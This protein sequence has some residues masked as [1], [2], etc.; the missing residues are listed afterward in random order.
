MLNKQNMKMRIFIFFL[1]IGCYPFLYAQTPVLHFSHITETDGLSNPNVHCIY[2]D[3][4]GFMWF[5][6][7][8]GLDQYDGYKFRK[9]VPVENDPSSISTVY[10]RTILGTNEGNLWIGTTDGLNFYDRKKDIFI[11]YATSKID[12]NSISADD[13]SSIV[14][15][16]DSN[17]WLGTTAGGLNYFDRKTKKFTHYQN[18]PGSPSSIYSNRIQNLFLDKNQNLWIGTADGVLDLSVKNS[19]QFQHIHLVGKNN[20][21]ENVDQIRAIIQDRK[22]NYWIATSGSGLYKMKILPDK[23]FEFV[24]F[25]N[26]PKDPNTVSNNHVSQLIENKEGGLWIGT[27]NGG[28]NYLDTNETRFVHYFYNE[29]NRESLGHNSVWSLFQ[30]N[31]S[32]LWVGTFTAGLNLNAAN[33][34]GFRLY[35]NIPGDTKSLSHNTVSAFFE[36]HT[37]TVWVGTDGGGLNSFNKTDGSFKHY[38]KNNAKLGS[39]AVLCIY[40]DKH[41]NLWVGTW[42]GG[43]NLLDR[44]T[45]T[46]KQFTKENSGLGCNNIITIME[47]TRGV[48][49]VGTFWG[50]GGISR[51]DEEQKRFIT[52]KAE[53]SGLPHNTVYSIINGSDNTLYLATANGLSNFDPVNNSFKNYYTSADNANSLSNNTIITLLFVKDSILWIGTAAGLN[54]LNVKT[55]KFKRYLVKDGLPN[56]SIVGIEEDQ[57]GNIWLSTGNG[58]SRLDPKTGIFKNFDMSDGLQG[59]SFYRCSHYK[60]KHGEIYFGGTK[61]YNV[62]D[63]KEITELRIKP[64]IYLTEFR[65]FNENVKVAAKN[66]PLQKQISEAGEIWLR[67]DQSVITFEFAAIYYAAPEKITYEYKLE[68]FDKAWNPV[69]EERAATYTNLNPGKYTFRVRI[70][71]KNGICNEEGT[72]IRVIVVPPFWM[73]WWFR[74]ILIFTLALILLTIFMLRTKSIQ[75]R[76]KMLEEMVDK[77]TRELQQK[78]EIMKLQSNELNETNTLLEERQQQIEEQAETLLAQKLELEHFNEELHELNATKDKFFSIIAHDIKNPFNTIL[79]FAEL[80]IHNFSKW[81]DEKK[82]Q[83][84]QVIFDSSQGLFEL[85]ENLLQW[86]RS[87]RGLIEF[88][89]IVTDLN[90]Q[91]NVAISLLKDSA[92]A[93]KIEIIP[94]FQDNDIVLTADLRMLDTIFRNILSN[95]IKFTPTGGNVR[96]TTKIENNFAVASFNDSGVGM[97]EEVISRLFRIDVHHTSTGTNEEKGTGLGLILVKEFI[98]KH[99]GKIEVQSAVD[100][101]STFILKFPL[102]K[103]GQVI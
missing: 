9:F 81:T 21:K 74:I 59:K 73:T 86:S 13:V 64:P 14:F 32:N 62:Y 47:D 79:G 6:T 57:E 25:R 34:T 84:I 101:G 7:E 33:K 58:L 93:K 89:P 63:P 71:C 52:Y 11:Q 83:I 96:I 91:I 67:Y 65:I 29:M 55:N 46:F 60:S 18:I 69:R 15:D 19:S 16:C 24:N 54:K 80:L 35:K 8:D 100:K 43:L 92:E 36:D 50:E 75:E 82:L 38:N 56:A 51:Y 87:Q 77:R 66:S 26:D 45:G 103:Q 30:D 23:K 78:N 17:L 4:K 2:Q 10:I 27:E 99:G 3:S 48:L 95:G 39:D 70:P 90:Q 53:N 42:D 37:N 49:W 88:D 28:L 44:K 98:T 22:G 20:G 40:E 72:S 31:L 76:N 85:L 12:S 97:S 41:Y 68:N 5:G 61:G 102:Q 1:L 94:D